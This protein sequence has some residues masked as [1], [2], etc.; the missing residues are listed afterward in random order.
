MVT[1]C[2][3]PPTQHYAQPTPLRFGERVTRSS[4]VS[5][6]TPPGVTEF[7]AKEVF[8]HL[9][10][11]RFPASVDNHS[12]TL[13]LCLPCS[14]YNGAAWAWASRLFVTDVT[15]CTQLLSKMKGHVTFIM[16]KFENIIILII[17][18]NEHMVTCTCREQ[19]S[20]GAPRV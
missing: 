11:G 18:V 3:A 7:C 10:D 2:T 17:A 15:Y 12:H 5:D 19:C 13:T 9:F 8:T 14:L 16:E 1:L 20:R 4:G 6:V